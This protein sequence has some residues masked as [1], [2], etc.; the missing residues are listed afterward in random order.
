MVQQAGSGFIDN[1]YF[2]DS[3]DVSREILALGTERVH[4]LWPLANSES[5]YF[6]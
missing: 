3:M 4:F 5:R 2:R 1:A 6:R